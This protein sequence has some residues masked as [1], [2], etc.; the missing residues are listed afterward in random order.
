MFCPHCG[1]Q[2]E[3]GSAFCPMCGQGIEA[4][5]DAAP[6]VRAVEPPP[7][8]TPLAPAPS[9][10]PPPVPP[11]VPQVPVQPT[12]PMAPPPQA[13][14]VPAAAPVVATPAAAPY[15]GAYPKAPLGGRLLAVIVD[16]I[17]A[18]A[19]L[20]PGILFLY[21]GLASGGTPA[22]GIA[23]VVI[24]GI[25]E[26]V[27]LLGR[28][29]FGGAGFGKR[30][31]GLVVVTSPGGVPAGVGASI[32]RQ[33]VLY[34][35]SV[36]PVIGSL[37]EPILVITDKDGRRLGDKAAKTQVARATDV[38]A[39]GHRV[40]A[41]KGLA[42]AALVI[43]LLVSLIGSA[44]GG[45]MFAGALAYVDGGGAF[46][47]PDAATV[48]ETQEDPTT[49]QPAVSELSPEDVV[50][51]FYAAVKD[52]DT[53]AVSALMTDEINAN[54]E[55]S[56]FMDWGVPVVEILS[57]ED[58][59]DGTAVVVVEEF[60]NDSSLG[61]ATYELI[62]ED[63]W[64]IAGWEMTI[65]EPDAGGESPADA[66][67]PETATDAVGIMLNALIMDD[68][69]TVREQ[70]TDRFEAESPYFFESTGGAFVQFEIVD[71]FQDGGTY[72]V[73]AREEWYSGP[74]EIMYIV[75]LE[76]GVPRVDAQIFD[77]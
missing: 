68:L 37:V 67:N 70:A 14:A 6:D 45:V 73:I 16:G 69:D 75:V 30:L 40:P 15:T 32:V 51:A 19:L 38:A 76:D 35:L 44:I 61:F 74:E 64:K 12:V 55:L 48:P 26:L 41:G 58:F 22:L 20:G 50:M 31:T 8:P 21:A 25:W 63:G 3:D 66:L 52:G 33:L 1:A 34:L 29:G 71:A 24:G 9:Q 13:P 49:E 47:I 4:A 5:P 57:A 23:L 11:P 2:V 27:Y 56:E 43:A 77:F 36:I 39:A 65:E 42:V 54:V 7:L 18:A 46:E 72:A 17:I 62:D 10:V 53:E 60:D 28:D 59:G